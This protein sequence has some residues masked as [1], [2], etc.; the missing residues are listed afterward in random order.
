MPW[1]ML[2][3]AYSRKSIAVKVS[4]A[5]GAG[6]TSDLCAGCVRKAAFQTLIGFLP[7]DRF[8]RSFEELQMPSDII[9]GRIFVYACPLSQAASSKWK[10]W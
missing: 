3:A 5:T 10:P 9:A 4:F 8:P 2:G 6:G 1:A 7:E